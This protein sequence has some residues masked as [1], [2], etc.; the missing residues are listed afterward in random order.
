[1]VLVYGSTGVY[2][3][4]FRQVII[5]TLIWTFFFLSHF[6]SPYKAEIW[7]RFRFRWEN[8]ERAGTG[9]LVTK[10]FSTRL[11]SWK[12]DTFTCEL[13]FPH[14]SFGE[15]VGGFGAEGE[16]IYRY[17]LQQCDDACAEMILKYRRTS[18]RFLRKFEGSREW[19]EKWRNEEKSRNFF[20]FRQK[21]HFLK[22]LPKFSFPERFCHFW[23]VLKEER[24]EEIDM[25]F[26]SRWYNLEIKTG[27]EI[28]WIFLNYREQPKVCGNE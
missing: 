1:M 27:A 6:R 10:E 8:I 11:H 13:K 3:Y 16:G 25:S 24:G 26:T 7:A 4:L 28:S 18:F 9:Y 2:E 17:K 14:S 20:K 12:G 5:N 23:Q 19:V 21:W 22:F 15:V